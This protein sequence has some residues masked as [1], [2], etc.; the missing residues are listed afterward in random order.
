MASEHEVIGIA[1]A[2]YYGPTMGLMSQGVGRR[3]ARAGWGSLAVEFDV[4]AAAFTRD[5][6]GWRRRVSV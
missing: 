1:T 3:M 2:A 4:C 6:L 5:T